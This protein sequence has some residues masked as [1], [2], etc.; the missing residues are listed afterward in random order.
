MIEELLEWKSS[1]SSQ[2]NWINDRGDP[3]RWL[4]ATEFSF[5]FSFSI[6]M[7]N[8]YRVWE[9]LDKSKGAETRKCSSSSN[10]FSLRMVTA[11]DEITTYGKFEQLPTTQTY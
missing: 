2:E 5:G 9:K 11:S 7:I 3:L 10:S 1:G 6:R 4:K 8:I